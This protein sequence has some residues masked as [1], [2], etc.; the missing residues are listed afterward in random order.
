MNVGQ[1]GVRNVNRDKNFVCAY[2]ATAGVPPSSPQGSRVGY[3]E[4]ITQFSLVLTMVRF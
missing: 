2:I 1:H 3:L 4:T